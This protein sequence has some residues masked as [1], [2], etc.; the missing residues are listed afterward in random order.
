MAKY[1]GKTDL[2]VIT[3][4]IMDI[5]YDA[6][7]FIESQFCQEAFRHATSDPKQWKWVKVHTHRRAGFSTAALQLLNEYRSSLIVTHSQP[8]ANRLRMEALDRNLVPDWCEEDFFN[9]IRIN[10]HIVSHERMDERWF[11]QRAPNERYQL[12][13]LDC[14]SMI[15]ASRNNRHRGAIPGMDEFRERMFNISDLVVELE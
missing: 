6:M 12:I 4:Q 13:I 5:V 8:A 7:G 14:A 3:D 2:P 11:I 10:D 1:A 9:N 15:E